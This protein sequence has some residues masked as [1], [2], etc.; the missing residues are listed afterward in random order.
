[1]TAKEYL[2]RLWQLNK[3]IDADLAKVTDLKRQTSKITVAYSSMPGSP[4]RNTDKV[5]KLVA[6]IVD[7]QHQADAKIDRLVDLKCEVVEM[8]SE[9]DEPELRAVLE[10]RYLTFKEWSDVALAMQC[11]ERHVYKLHRKAMESFE[12]IL[13]NSLTVQSVGSCMTPS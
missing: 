10:L 9:I 1:M 8:L 7:L 5:E 11:G 13:K 6:R 3:E 4:N 2:D 12:N